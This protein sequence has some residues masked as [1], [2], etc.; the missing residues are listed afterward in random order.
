VRFIDPAPAIARRVR[1]LLDAVRG[2]GP[3]LPSKMVFTSGRA[4]PAPLAVALARFGLAV[5][6]GPRER[7]C[8]TEQPMNTRPEHL[9][10]GAPQ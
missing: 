10:P 4:P 1:E 8:P 6:D 7:A 3:R 5:A 9:A 2:D